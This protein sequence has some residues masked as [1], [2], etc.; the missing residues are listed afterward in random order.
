MPIKGLAN[1]G[2]EEL[3]VRFDFSFS[4]PS[5]SLNNLNLKF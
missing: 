4:F 1:K 2:K 3:K 5:K